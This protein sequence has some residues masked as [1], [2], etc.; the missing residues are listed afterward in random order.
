MM[1]KE[2]QKIKLVDVRESGLEGGFYEDLVP[3]LNGKKKDFV[4]MYEA[5]KVIKVLE[6]IKKSNKENRFV[7]F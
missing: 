4:S 5:A 1:V 2:I 7:E 6:N 3:Y